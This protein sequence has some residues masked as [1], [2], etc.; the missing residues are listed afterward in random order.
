MTW[1]IAMQQRTRGHHLGVEQGV[2]GQQA[3]EVAAMPITPIHHRGN[4]NSPGIK[5]KHFLLNQ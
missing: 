2:A 4:R 3:V 5:L 1:H